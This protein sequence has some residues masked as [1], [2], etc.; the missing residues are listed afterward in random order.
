VK[1]FEQFIFNILGSK[2][3]HW[4]VIFLTLAALVGSVMML[5]TKIVLAKM[6][7]GKSANTYS[8]Y[9][10]AP[11]DSSIEETKKMG[12]F[13]QFIEEFT[14]LRKEKRPSYTTTV[15]KIIPK[16]NSGIS[17][18]VFKKIYIGVPVFLVVILITILI[19]PGLNLPQSITRLN[20]QGNIQRMLPL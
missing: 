10:N 20:F 14:V 15:Q 6:L 2:L 12:T 19:I 1:K 4:M 9:V 8:I 7:P 16:E 11:T 5:P 18:N 3:K 13:E 17:A